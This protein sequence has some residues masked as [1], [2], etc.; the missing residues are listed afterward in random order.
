[1]S[2]AGRSRGFTLLEL[3]VS[4]GILAALVGLVLQLMT[5]T[6]RGRDMVLEGMRRP[7]VSNAIISQIVK[8]L[9]YVWFGGLTGNA[10]FVGRSRTVGGK[11]GDRIDFITAR[12]ARTV[13]LDEENKDEDRPMSN[14][15]EVGYALRQ[16]DDGVHLELWRREDAYVDDD[17]ANGGAYTLIYGRVR[18][19][20]WTYYDRP[21]ESPGN[22]G[23]EEWDSRVK[24]R[25]PYALILQLSFDVEDDEE[26]RDDAEPE[27]LVRIF[28]LKPGSTMAVDWPASGTPAGGAAMN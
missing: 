4:L 28:L 1:M 25:V 15:S 22:K 2:R 8:D 7:K 13:E 23:H 24:R 6:V 19:L 27:K 11:D 20:S 14:L 21:G 10:G 18:E 12:L 16:S 3:I 5:L 26:R 17:P 9:R